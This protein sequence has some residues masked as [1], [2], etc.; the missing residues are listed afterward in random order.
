MQITACMNLVNVGNPHEL[1]M[2]ELAAEVARAVGVEPRL[3][4]VP[5]Y[6]ES[7]RQR[8]PDIYAMLP[9]CWSPTVPISDG[10]STVAYFTAATATRHPACKR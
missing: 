4:Y 5:A 6:D 2:G 8:C 3:R 1:T 7:S 10:S 9:F